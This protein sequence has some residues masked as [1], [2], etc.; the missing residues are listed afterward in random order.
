MRMNMR[1]VIMGCRDG[2]KKPLT[3]GCLATLPNGKSGA[4]PKYD[5]KAQLDEAAQDFGGG[6]CWLRKKPLCWLGDYNGGIIPALAD[7]KEAGTV[8]E[9]CAVAARQAA[10]HF[11]KLSIS[12]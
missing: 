12:D 10:R 9:R 4:G 6:D 1:A 3:V 2:R 8:G 7:M 11:R 5:Y